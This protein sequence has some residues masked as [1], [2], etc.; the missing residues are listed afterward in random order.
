MTKKAWIMLADGFE[1]TEAMGTWDALQRGG[2]EAIFVSINDTLDVEG[3]HGLEWS[4]D[5]TIDAIG[6]ELADAI[7]LPGGGVGADNLQASAKVAEL[8]RCHHKDGKVVAAIC[9]APKVLGALGLLEGRKATAYPGFEALLTGATPQNA[10]S[11]IDGNIVTGR[12]P[13][14]A[15]HFG[16]SIL[17]LLV[18]TDKAREVADGLLITETDLQ[19]L[20]L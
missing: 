13:A 7:V 2:V 16:V 19:G 5:T 12:G 1:E 11:V 15:F 17:S 4:A 20:H 14:Y 18:G 3:A 6:D 9:A 8:L 10:V